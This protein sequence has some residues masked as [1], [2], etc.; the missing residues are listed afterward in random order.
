M[1]VIAVAALS[2]CGSAAVK[3]LPPPP[4]TRPLSPTTTV[5]LPDLTGVVLKGVPGAMRPTVAVGPGAARLEGTVSGPEGPV[6][7]AVVHAERLVGETSAAVDVA[8]GADGRW[9]IPG[10]LG[11]RYRIR[12][13]RAPDLALLQPAVLYLAGQETRAVNLAVGRYGTPPAVVSAIAPNPPASNQF[14][15]LAL[16]I[17]QRTVDP[18]GIV[19]TAPLAG[20]EVALLASAEWLVLS[21]NPSLTDSS[22]AVHWDVWCAG[23]GSHPLWVAVAGSPPSQVSV[24]ACR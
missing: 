22:G 16:R 7:G 4:P 20:A 14:A 12:A 18:G 1:A 6:A 17:T 3:P 5:A 23:P 10:I 9:V 8:T 13:W 2:A 19:R 11:G 15:N 24:P 21:A